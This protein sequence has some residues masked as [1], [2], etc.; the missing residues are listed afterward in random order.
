[1]E[2]GRQ[3][4]PDAGR[5]RGDGHLAHAAPVIAET[6]VPL[7]HAAG[8]DP[9]LAQRPCGADAAAGPERHHGR[10][11]AADA[12]RRGPLGAGVRLGAGVQGADVH[13]QAHGRL[14]RAGAVQLRRQTLL[15]GHGRAGAGRPVRQG[16]AAAPDRAGHVDAA[17]ASTSSSM[18]C[19]A[20][21]SRSSSWVARS[22]YRRTDDPNAGQVVDTTLPTRAADAVRFKGGY[23]GA[24]DA[25]YVS[26]WLAPC[27]NAHLPGRGPHAPCQQVSWPSGSRWWASNCGRPTATTAWS[28][29]SRPTPRSRPT[30][31]APSS[32][33]TP[34]SRSAAIRQ[35]GNQLV[36]FKEDGSLFTLNSDGTTN[37]LF[38]GLTV[39]ISPD[40]GLRAAAWL[41]SLW[42]RAGP[43]FYRLGMP[44]ADLQPAGPGR[45]LDNGS[46][47][48]GEVRTWCGLGRLPGVPHPVQP[49]RPAPPT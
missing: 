31:P 19:M 47:V 24:T 34:A 21:R 37:D 6:P 43:S 3:A 20:A 38:P 26:P 11:Q 44:G 9:R 36:I 22:V 35:T 10:S 27:T 41:D 4:H 16:A 39:P 7:P 5:R 49:D 42:F 30:G 1:M 2:Y 17:G 32:W 12:G 33:A 48:R 14:R 28:A 46:P 13:G 23:G 29:T 40:N 45:M 18:A 15:L 8:F 25:L